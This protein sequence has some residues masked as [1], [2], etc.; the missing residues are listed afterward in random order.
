MLC[1]NIYDLG[2]FNERTPDVQSPTPYP[3]LDVDFAGEN[4]GDFSP[5][6]EPEHSVMDTLRA[7]KPQLRSRPPIDFNGQNNYIPS[8]MS[9]STLC[10]DTSFPRKTSR[11]D[12]FQRF[13]PSL[14]ASLTIPE[15]YQNPHYCDLRERYDYVT[16][17]LATYLDRG[18]TSTTKSDVPIPDICQRAYFLFLVSRHTL[19]WI[20]NSSITHGLSHFVFGL[21]QCRLS[22]V[23]CGSSQRGLSRLSCV[24]VFG[25]Q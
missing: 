9:G 12:S 2:C 20:Y 13:P 14:I 1:D 10:T 5:E 17:V 6:L 15:L 8:F 4:A 7:S 21:S 25:I 3:S 16:R 24:I 18:L 23:V 22:W 11:G 19:N